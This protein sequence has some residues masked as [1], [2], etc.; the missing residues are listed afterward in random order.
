MCHKFSKFRCIHKHSR[1]D[2]STS[3]LMWIQRP[4]IL[5][6]R[7]SRVGLPIFIELASVRYVLGRRGATIVLDVRWT[8]WSYLNRFLSCWILIITLP[9]SH[10]AVNF[11]GRGK[12][13]AR[14]NEIRN[15]KDSSVS[16]HC[17]STFPMDGSGLTDWPLNHVPFSCGALTRFQV[18]GLRDHT[19]WT[20]HTR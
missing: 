16:A 20:H 1:T 2:S 7:F 14:K 11:V 3:S 17:A 8:I 13:F 4:L 10:W 12:H 19:Y 18:T 5:T 15:G 6:N 9:H